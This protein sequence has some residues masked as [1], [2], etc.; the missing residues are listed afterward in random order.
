M[1]AELSLPAEQPRGGGAKR[2]ALIYFI[3]GNPGLVAF[4]ADFLRCMRTLLGSRRGHRQTAYDIYGRN[5][6]GFGDEEH[7]PF[8]RDNLPWDLKGQI[9]G[10]Y[11]HVAARRTQEGAPYDSVILMGHSVGAYIAVEIFHRHTKSPDEKASH[12]VL[13]HGLLLFP[14]LSHISLSLSGQRAS[15]LCRLP[16]FEAYAHLVAGALLL[17]VP[18]ATLRWVTRRLLGFD[19]P[20]AATAAAWLKSRDGVRQAIHLGMSELRGIGEETWGEALWEVSAEAG[21]GAG[22]GG[23]GGEAALPKFFMFYGREDHWVADHVRDDFIARRREH[24]ERGGRTKIVVDEGSIPHAFCV[25][26]GMA[27]LCVCLSRVTSVS[28]SVVFF[29]SGR[30]WLTQEQIPL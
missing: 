5:L 10:V 21:G 7:E 14:T 13:D 17:L 23:D 30:W 3:C 26:E 18:E 11:Q 15:L 20:G 27:N 8:G 12:L 22:A 28:T 1:I 4:Y 24:G 9:G 16:G 6:L 25:R 29:V 19:G 2:R